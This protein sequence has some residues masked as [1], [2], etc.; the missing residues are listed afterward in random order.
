MDGKRE[1]VDS[2]ISVGGARS[3]FVHYS[4]Q[5]GHVSGR[6]TEDDWLVAQDTAFP[7]ELRGRLTVVLPGHA[8]LLN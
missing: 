5:I 1:C 4:Q 8:E 7:V 6:L 3:D 2:G